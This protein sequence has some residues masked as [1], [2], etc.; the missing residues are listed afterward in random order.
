MLH[1]F[2]LH[3]RLKRL[4]LLTSV[5][6]L[7]LLLSACQ[8]YDGYPTVPP[9]PTSTAAPKATPT[10]TPRP[11]LAAPPSPTP[12]PSL[13]PAPSGVQSTKA[14]ILKEAFSNLIT[15]Y[16]QPLA[17]ADIYE[18][19]LR[20][21]EMGLQQTGVD[22]AARI[23]LPQFGD[24]DDANWGAFL[25]AYTLILDKY[26]GKVTEDQL[27]QY[28]L[29]GASSSLQDCKT[30][31]FPPNLAEGYFSQ[32]TGQASTVG[33][34]INLQS[35]QTTSGSA[36]HLVARTIAGGP[37]EKAGL[38]L[39][40]QIVAID[41]QELSTKNSTQVIQLLQGTVRGDQAAGTR[42]SLTI[43]R[44]GTSQTID[45]TRNR[46][47]VPPMERY[48]L[49]NTTGYIRFNQFPLSSQAQLGTITTTVGTWIG[50]FEKAGVSGY[51]LDL[52]GNSNGSISLVQNMLSYFMSG[53][54]LVYLNGQ[55]AGQNT[56]RTYGPFPM[57]S[58]KDIKATDKPVAVLVDGG[59][60][61]EAEIFAYAIQR[62]KRGT[63]V[64]APTA[65]CLNAST[66]VGLKDN[67]L[68]N[69]T[70]YRAISD[71]TKPESIVNSVE[72]DQPATPD[73]QQLSEGK[74]S[75]LDAA[76]KALKK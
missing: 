67:S 64:G 40:D 33:I 8:T 7:A 38:K 28:A 17:S 74:D 20:S 4:A 12:R 11:I 61:G 27:A 46:F 73:L 36:A 72:P 25:Q 51:V 60:S 71:A 39:G 3:S 57:P 42:V 59:T 31:Y 49:D 58:N 34:G 48:L 50:D 70:I 9:E 45:I 1:K 62:G 55:T 30:G 52:R 6:L 75:Q 41:G 5:C 16:F 2:H 18:V 53:A 13:P 68:I 29:T 26:K 54:E 47:Q 76:I 24:K 19:G 56:Q 63:L 43:R 21:I 66:P 23:P 65:G 69:I 15:N 37:A 32:R 10:N 22:P 14:E 35:G 44:A